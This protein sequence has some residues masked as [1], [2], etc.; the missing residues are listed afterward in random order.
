[1]SNEKWYDQQNIR[2]NTSYE[3]KPALNLVSGIHKIKFLNEGIDISSEWEGKVIP[4]RV[5]EV[6]CENKAWAWF[7]PKGQTKSS[8]FGQ[9][10]DFAKDNGGLTGNTISLIVAGKGKDKRY[11][12]EGGNKSPSSK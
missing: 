12:I 2:E 11:T 9:I 3:R 8:L 7:V 6:Q 1:M 4:K 5:F 10:V